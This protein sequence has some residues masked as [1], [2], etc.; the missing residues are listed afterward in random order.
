M[1]IAVVQ[2][3]SG[4]ATFTSGTSGTL[5][6][7]LGQAT[8]SGNCLI[9]C[10]SVG[11]GPADPSVSGVTLGGVA[12]DWAAVVTGAAA[13]GQNIAAIWADPS[14]ASGQTSVAVTAAFGGTAS[15]SSSVAVLADVYEVS[16]LAASAVADKT[17]SA[18]GASASWS[19][20][21]TATTS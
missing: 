16:G 15:G 12:G 5:T 14:A 7:T 2:H 10:I 19:S 20:G 1:T 9:A 4:T 18:K 6:V 17:I 13:S 3:A 21:T 11:S 8:G